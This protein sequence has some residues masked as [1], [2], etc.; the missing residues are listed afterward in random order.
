MPGAPYYPMQREARC[1]FAPAPA[2]RDMPP[3]GRVRIWDGSEPWFITRHADQRALLND[4]RLSIDEKRPGYPHMTRSRAAM[5]PH[6]PELITNTDPPQ[7]TRLRRTV[8]APFLVKRVELLRPRIQEILDSLI[9]DLLAGPKPADLVQT[10]GLP[11]PTLVITRILGAPYED[12]E[13]F[14]AA[15]HRA[16]SH[17]TDPE[18]AARSSRELG[19]YLGALLV[20]RMAEPAD[21]VLSEMGARVKAGEMTHA[22]AVTMGAAILIAGHETSAS[23]ISLGTLALLHNPGQLALLR[24]NSDDPKFVAGAVEELLRYLTIVH[25]GIRRIAIEDI[26]LHGTTIRAGD[27]VVFDL[28]GANY[29]PAE[30]PEPDRLDLTRRAR[31]HHAFGFGPHQC[32]GQSLARVELQ[33]AYSTLYRRIPTLALAVPFE[34]VP[35]AMDGVAYGLKSLPVTW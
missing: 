30:Y 1:P 21:D 19:E 15:S 13:F 9:D 2:V 20:K 31:S 3:L 8:N 4:P 32:L 28:A 29:D 14:Q 33:V 26:E 17:D 35:F 12:H 27:G 23:M 24:D 6:I 10:I 18:D 5:A 7:H 22:E 16:I 34:E 11:V 25:S